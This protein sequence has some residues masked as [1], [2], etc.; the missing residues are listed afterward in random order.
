VRPA[1][2]WFEPA[3]G[4]R[5]FRA[6]ERLV[7]TKVKGW[8]DTTPIAV[9]IR[10]MTDVEALENSIA[11]HISHQDLTPAEEAIAFAKL[12]KLG[13]KPEDIAAT[14]AVTPRFVSQR[15]AIGRLPATIL[16][17]LKAQEIDTKTAE[18]LTL[19]AD[20]KEQLRLFTTLG[21]R[22]NLNPQSVRR[23]LV[24][25]AL[26]ANDPHARFV[27]DKAYRDAGG[28]ITEDLFGE[29]R[30]Y[31][32][33]KLLGRLFDTKVQATA[34]ALESEG[35]SFVK[36][37]RD[38]WHD[39][40]P[41]SYSGGG[42]TRL[43]PKGEQ[44]PEEKK[45]AAAIDA[46]IGGVKKRIE[47][48]EKLIDREDGYDQNTYEEKDRLEDDVLSALEEERASIPT[49]SFTADQKTKSGVII[50]IQPNRFEIM[51]GMVDP[52]IAKAAEKE[53]AKAKKKKVKAAS[54]AGAKASTA[55][56]GEIEEP[57]FSGALK[58]DLAK[59]MG[60]ALQHAIAG[61]PQAAHYLLVA[62]LL[63]EA[64]NDDDSAFGF[65][66]E[67][68]AIKGTA[69]DGGVGHFGYGEKPQRTKASQAFED[70][71]AAELRRFHPPAPEGK[72]KK[73]QGIS[74]TLE[75]LLTQ[76]ELLEHQDLMRLQALLVAR[77][78]RISMGFMSD[79]DVILTIKRF[80][81]EV[82]KWWTPDAEFFKRLK[83]PDLIEA[84]EESAA[85][86]IPKSGSKSQLVELAA[87][88]LPAKGWLPKP[89]RSPC[90]AGPGSNAWADAQG[91]KVADAAAAQPMQIAAE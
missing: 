32:D 24:G 42:W 37:A 66:A 67:V 47:E 22:T 52:A 26:S 88:D 34:K 7:K 86:N 13:K 5:R 12:A 83:K 56:P 71:L 74:I 15:L 25:K 77:S 59:E 55:K 54:G 9:S 3:D 76:L 30:W 14:Y 38:H 85:V 68:I 16:Q 64:I 8:T 29:D 78:L 43:M 75:H 80:D 19:T 4:G 44:L 45:R 17:A 53:K 40:D 89:L 60:G 79:P 57:D 51:R 87:A 11:T 28:V 33:G 72:A 39:Y 49:A 91:A 65:E 48:L 63:M 69:Y 84:L 70:H 2:K 41:N 50:R 27:G 58:A 18:A 21:K 23:E 35:W 90:Y 61:K 73:H 46:E 62:T 31:E 1:G 10:K 81:P 6:I 82:A 20:A 36:V